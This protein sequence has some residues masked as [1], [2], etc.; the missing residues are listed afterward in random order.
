MWTCARECPFEAVVFVH[1]IFLLSE[2]QEIS[3]NIHHQ[4]SII[5]IATARDDKHAAFHVRP[6]MIDRSSPP[7]NNGSNNYS[8]RLRQTGVDC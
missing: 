1:Y 2:W 6:K 3:F 5:A 8:P 7:T 4:A